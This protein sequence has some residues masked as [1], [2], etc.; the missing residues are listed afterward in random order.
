M[1]DTDYPG[2]FLL[3]HSTGKNSNAGTGLIGSCGDDLVMGLS[4]VEAVLLGEQA[5]KCIVGSIEKTELE[6]QVQQG[7]EEDFR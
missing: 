4:V 3:G 6:T 5:L 7:S 1:N 2:H